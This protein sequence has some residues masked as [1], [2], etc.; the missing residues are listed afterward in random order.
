MSRLWRD[1]IQ[2][3]LAPER[4]DIVRFSRGFKP[5][6]M[7]K[8]TALCQHVQGAPAWQAAL[9]Q[10]EKHLL[11]AVGTDLTITLSN[12]FT[13]Y[14]TLPPQTEITTPEEVMSYATFRMREIYAE[15]VDSWVLS[16]SDWNPISGAVCAAIPRELMTRLEEL[17][18][19]YQFKLKAV[20]PYLASVYDRW[21]KQLSGNRIY[22]A[23]IEN[24]RICLTILLDGVWQSIRNQ[25][26]LHSVAD[27]LLAALDQ[28]TILSGHKESVELVYLFAPEH[29]ELALPQNCGWSLIPLQTEQ[30]PVLAHYPSVA[31]NHTEI[32]QCVA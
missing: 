6:Q 31:V 10:L 23:V 27:E 19:R 25:R 18:V 21:E 16:V 22:L 30:L 5:V 1:Q 13:R 15:R 17:A 32:N 26:I 11:E 3:F 9:Q 4:M 29:P 12:H 7:S 24:G 28:E 8:A 20:E 14:V 2:V